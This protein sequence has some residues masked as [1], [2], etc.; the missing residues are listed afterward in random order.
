VTPSHT[1]GRLNVA[2]EDQPAMTADPTGKPS[3][4][5][6]VIVRGR[7]ALL[8]RRRVREGSLSWQF[9]AGEVEL[10]ESYEDAAVRETLEEVGLRVVSTELLGQRVHPGTGR[11]M[12]Y[13]ACRVAG[14]PARVADPDELAEVAWADLRDLRLYIPHG[15]FQPVQDYL[16]S[17]LALSAAPASA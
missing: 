1:L 3:I 10:G 8:V 7:R 2:L 17:V 5:A 9:P 11:D 12:V 14:G 16:D 15:L 6:A 13:I 4:A